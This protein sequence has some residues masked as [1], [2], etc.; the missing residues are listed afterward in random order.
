[1]ITVDEHQFQ[2]R[3]APL[4]CGLQLFIVG[5]GLISI[6]ATVWWFLTR[7]G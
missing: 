1:V 3:Y 5:C 2:I 4:A 7:G 6:I